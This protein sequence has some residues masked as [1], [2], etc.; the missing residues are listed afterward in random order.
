MDRFCRSLK[1][2]GGG[3]EGWGG[4]GGVRESE[5]GTEAFHLCL[6]TGYTVV[7]IRKRLEWPHQD[8]KRRH[9]NR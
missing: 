7:N 4:G 1:G 5:G 6:P 9:E 3:S 2:E 8:L